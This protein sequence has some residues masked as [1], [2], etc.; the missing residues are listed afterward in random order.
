MFLDEQRTWALLRELDTAEHPRDYN[1]TANRGRFEQ[2][3]TRV[4]ASFGHCSVEREAQWVP[5]HGTI[6]IPAEAT[7]ST[8]HLTLTVSNFG[9]LV[10]VTLGNPGS[11][12][13]EEEDVLFEQADRDRIGAALAALGYHAISEHL[14]WQTYD[15]A[16]PHHSRHGRFSWWDR[17]FDYL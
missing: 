10:A 7:A 17:F 11:H 13:Q 14:L 4:E 8:E 16:A 9:S 1:S 15:G 3:V 12:D 2:L 6:V 5:H